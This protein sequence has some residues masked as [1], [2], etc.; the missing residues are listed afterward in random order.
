M[1][2]RALVLGGGGVAGIGWTAGVLYGLSEAGTDWADADVV[3]G[4]SAGS[5]VAAQLLAADTVKEVY[6]R[7]LEAPSGEL[8]ARLGRGATFGLMW[9]ALTSRSPEAFGRR[10]GRLAL[11]ARTPSVAARR[12]AIESRLISTDWPE[13][14]LRITAVDTATGELSVFDTDSGVS[15]TDAVAA[16]CAVPGVWPAWPVQGRHWTDGGVHSP[17]NAHLAEGYDRVIVLAPL[18]RAG[19][20]I[21]SPAAQAAR[22]ESG[23]AHVALVTPSAAAREA[24]GTNALDPST[25]AKAARSGREQ[26]SAH[27][28]EVTR[29]WA[30]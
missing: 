2:K 3:I 28:E 14:A 13:R 1:T 21:A 22:L 29:V 10:I 23:G 26:A 8:P 25:R 20:A 12:A 30:V 27:A 17:A 19:G 9:A 16:S 5:T 6:D 24:M 11:T 4:T 15:L 7:Q 18:T